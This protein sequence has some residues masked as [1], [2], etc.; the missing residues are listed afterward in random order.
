MDLGEAA[1][2][3]PARFQAVRAA[4]EG[5]APRASALGVPTVEGG[6]GGGRA[7]QCDARGSGTRGSPAGP[8]P[9]SEARAT[10]RRFG[11]IRY[12]PLSKDRGTCDV[13][14]VCVSIRTNYGSAQAR[15]RRDSHRNDEF[16]ESSNCC[17]VLGCTTGPP[18]QADGQFRERFCRALLRFVL[19]EVLNRF[20]KV[21]ITWPGP[22]ARHRILVVPPP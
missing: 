6:A 8:G 19:D 4:P 17:P 22:A 10:L 16:N 12:N 3:R 14:L 15:C 11:T 13:R 18:P 5:A 21:A 2:E 9:P 1:P 7:D 20:V